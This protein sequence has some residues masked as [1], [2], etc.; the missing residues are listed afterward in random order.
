MRNVLSKDLIHTKVVSNAIIS[1]WSWKTHMEFCRS[2]HCSKICCLFPSL[3][4]S[5]QSQILFLEAYLLLLVKTVKA[6]KELQNTAINIKQLMCE[7]FNLNQVNLE[8][9]KM[10]EEIS[11]TTKNDIYTYKQ[12][13]IC[14]KDVLICK[15]YWQP[16]CSVWIS[17]CIY[18][19][20]H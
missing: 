10:I 12:L 8:F 18:T 4:V 15:V 17:V 20:P 13:I 9:M 1:L 2:N 19:S 5:H 16:N 6:C 3:T 7:I 11:K 14:I